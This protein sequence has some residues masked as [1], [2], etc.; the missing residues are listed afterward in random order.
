MNIVLYAVESSEVFMFNWIR[1]Q[2]C[3]HEF[4]HVEKVKY[5]DC[6]VDTFMCKYCGWIRKIET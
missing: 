1:R 6:I 5:K 3:K 2:R 4:I